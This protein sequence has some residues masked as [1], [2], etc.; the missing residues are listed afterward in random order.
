[1]VETRGTKAK[2]TAAA[3]IINM[4]E[5]NAPQLLLQQTIA[6][7]RERMLIEVE[8]AERLA[9]INAEAA[10][11]SAEAAERQ[12]LLEREKFEAAKQLEKEKA[13]AAERQAYAEKERIEAA[14]KLARLNAE[15]AQARKDMFDIDEG[16]HQPVHHASFKINEIS[17]LLPCIYA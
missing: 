15:L 6:L 8:R 12:A 9:K 5:Q 13:E 17:H 14:S 4:G 16:E 7:E 3:S 2:N 11:L 1:M 10:K